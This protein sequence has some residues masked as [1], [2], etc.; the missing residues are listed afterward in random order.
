[1]GVIYKNGIA[2]GGTPRVEPTVSYDDLEN[3]PRI[4][5]I[6]LTEDIT[7][8]DLDLVDGST[9]FVNEDDQLSISIISNNQ[10][11]A[12]FEGGG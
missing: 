5:N 1:M 12:L 10:I 7:T 3:K 6:P 9:I 8:S 2:Y 11:E 4:N